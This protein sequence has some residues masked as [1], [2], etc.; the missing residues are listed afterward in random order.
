MARTND[1]KELFRQ[2]LTQELRKHWMLFLIEGI[3]L[4]ILGVLAI[5]VPMI[6]TIPAAIVVGWLILISGCWVALL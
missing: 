2:V 4:V 3:V 5:L 1:R 6:A